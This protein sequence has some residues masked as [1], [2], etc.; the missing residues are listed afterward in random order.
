MTVEQVQLIYGGGSFISEVSN[1]SLS[2]VQ[3]TLNQLHSHGIRAIDTAPIYGR[4]EELLGQAHAADRF[5]LATKFPGGFL[6][7]PATKEVLLAAAEE[8]LRKLQTD[9]TCNPGEVG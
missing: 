6:P 1:R 8:S 4:S 5:A 2:D 9:Q 3:A 7:E